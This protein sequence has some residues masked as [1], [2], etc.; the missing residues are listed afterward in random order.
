[1]N[2]VLNRYTL[3]SILR[4]LDAALAE[5]RKTDSPTCEGS[6][7]WNVRRAIELLIT[8][9]I[10]DVEVEQVPAATEQREPV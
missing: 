8:V 10:G 1:M 5:S 4:H 7:T 9:A 6:A 2:A 3:C